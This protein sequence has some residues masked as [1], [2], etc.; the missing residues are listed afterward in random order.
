MQFDRR[1]VLAGM[2]AATFTMPAMAALPAGTA[3]LAE[4]EQRTFRFFRDHVN[5]ANGLVPDRWPTPSFASIAAVGFALNAWGIGVERGWMT[6]AEARR[7][8]LN[9]LRFFDGAPSGD[10]RGG[11]SGHR[12]FFYHFLDMQTGLRFREC[13]LSTVDT[14]LL[15][16]GVLFAGGFFDADHPQEAEIRRLSTT[17]VDRAEWDWALA[18]GRGISMGWHPETGFIERI[19]DGYNEGKMVY[20]LALGSGGHP[21]ADGRW[22]TWTANYDRFWRGNG[23]TRHLAF[24]PLFGHQ[25]SETWID[26]RGIRDAPMRA[27]GFDYFENARRATYANRAWCAANPMGWAGYSDT[28]W[29]LTACDGPAGVTLPWRG[30]PARFAAY[31]ARGP[32]DQ[33]DGFDDGTIAPTAALSSI[34]FAPEIVIPAAEALARFQGGRLY[35]RYGFID[36]FNPSFRDVTVP[37]SNGRVD[38]ELGWIGGDYLGIDQG[39][40]LSMIANW[41]S[42]T[43]WRVMRRVP[44]IRRGLTRAGFTGGW[45]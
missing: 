24:A 22:S 18:D 3:L 14:A 19:W 44:Q 34:A 1:Q 45:L 6:R 41:R 20:I 7:L 2:G 35:G 9:T 42:D 12:G 29:G 4:I 16:L 10:A 5:P 39:P 28:I 37:V 38:P 27:A 23:P 36:A 17:I 40:I 26:F 8:T 31:S 15:H 33:P 11:V 13:E 21:I 30:K 25:Y 32:A 43:I